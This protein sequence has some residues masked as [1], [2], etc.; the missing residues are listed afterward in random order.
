M[1]TKC[2]E[3]ISLQCGQCRWFNVNA[4]LPNVESTCKRLDHKHLK[5]AKKI[6]KCYDCGQTQETI[7]RDF[8]P[9]A[10]M[11]WLFKNWEMIKAQI[12]PYTDKD[13]IYINVDGDSDVRYGV[14]ATD[15]YDNTFIEK[16]GSLKW[17]KKYYM[18]QSCKTITGYVIVN[19]TR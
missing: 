6:F 14:R 11:V 4:D 9:R 12:I 15:F 19:E 2:E 10:D 5:F 1:N 7:C 17:V 18:K 8:E 16:D 13:I 3:W